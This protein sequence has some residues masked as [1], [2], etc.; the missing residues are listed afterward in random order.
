MHIIFYNLKYPSDA[1]A[2]TM[3]D[4]LAVMA[5]F[6]EVNLSP[7]YWMLRKFERFA[8]FLLCL[9]FFFIFCHFF[10]FFSICCYFPPIFIHFSPFF[11]I[12]PH[13]FQFFTNFSIFFQIFSDF[14]YRLRHMTIS[15]MTL[16]INFRTSSLQAHQ[17]PM[18]LATDIL[19]ICYHW[20]RIR[21]THTVVHWPQSH[22]VS[23]LYGLYFLVACSYQS[24]RL[25]QWSLTSTPFFWFVIKL[26]VWWFIFHFVCLVWIA[27]IVAVVDAKFPRAAR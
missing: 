27:V 2:R 10:P 21:T 26:K 19:H 17:P 15:S 7:L 23:Q 11:S 25:V 6:F 18:I 1:V 13:F 8:L 14:F 4:G 5:T 20:I 22:F 24:V 9:H 12:F 3:T 16:P